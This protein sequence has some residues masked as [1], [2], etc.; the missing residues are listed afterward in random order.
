MIKVQGL[1]KRY[2]ATLAVDE[3]SFDVWPGRL[4][5]FLGPNGSGKSTT[6]RMIMGLDY[7]DAGTATVNHRR[8]SDA[9]WPMR[10]VGAV[11][12]AQAFHPGRRARDHLQSLA[13]T[14]DIA[15]TRVDEVLDLVGLTTVARRRL[16]TY[17]LGMAQRLSI[18]AALLGDP[19]VL[20]FD[21][22]ING[23]DPEGVRWVRDLMKS[24]AAQGRTVLVSSHMMSEM[25]LTAD[26]VVIVGRGRLIIEASV[27]DLIARSP[28]H[29]V[30]VRTDAPRELS[31]LLSASGATIQV[32]ADGAL[33]VRGLDPERIAS[34]ADANAL[35][36][37]E[38]SPQGGSLEATYMQITHDS[39]EFRGTSD[40]AT[41]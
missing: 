3:L 39:V 13:E 30:R 21:E 2:G 25:A 33:A 28:E 1:V 14:N 19:D 27:A 7:P 34:L 16:R 41:S 5:G 35:F 8:L 40:Q 6:I 31:A 24:F 15:R 10:E 11:L 36:I 18:A 37:G 12:D 32:E 17:S 23:L 4:T 38:L 20:I 9:P 26:H 29:F 22:P